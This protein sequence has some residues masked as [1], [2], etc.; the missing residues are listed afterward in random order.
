MGS[1]KSWRTT[2]ILY[3]FEA[4]STSG[5]VRRHMGHCKSSKT[6]IAICAPLGGRNT[7]LTVSCAEAQTP[8][9]RASTNATHKITKRLR[10]M[11]FMMSVTSRNRLHLK[12][13]A[14]NLDRATCARQT[15]GIQKFKTMLTEV[16]PLC[17]DRQFV[18]TA[19]L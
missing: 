1:G 10:N 16:S 4:C 3:V 13:D 12:L 6:T 7:E 14:E 2:G 15:S 5:A 18:G 19:G 8:P 17:L 11:F 9:A